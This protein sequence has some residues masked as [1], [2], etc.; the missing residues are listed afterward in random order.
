M[1]AENLGP[2]SQSRTRSYKQNSNV[3][4]DSVKAKSVKVYGSEGSGFEFPAAVIALSSKLRQNK[5]FLLQ[6]GLLSLAA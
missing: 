5:S 2:V 1:K 6:L 3:E 4:F